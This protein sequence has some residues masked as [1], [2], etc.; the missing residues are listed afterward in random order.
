MRSEFSLDGY[1]VKANGRRRILMRK[2]IRI[3]DHRMDHQVSKTLIREY[4]RNP[5]QRDLGELWDVVKEN[6]LS[7][8]VE[9]TMVKTT[10]MEHQSDFSLSTP[11]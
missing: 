11:K 2:K 1:F 10:F 7:T 3:T 5:T 9:A 8:Q 6:V 4:I